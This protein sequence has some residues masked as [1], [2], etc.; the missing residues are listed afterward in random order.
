MKISREDVQRF[1]EDGAVILRQ[2]FDPHWIQLVKQGIR[3][4][5]QDPSCYSQ[6]LQV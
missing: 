3:L 5:L 2:V 6:S 4:N 1:H